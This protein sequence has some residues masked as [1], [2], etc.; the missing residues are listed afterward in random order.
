M[1]EMNDESIVDKVEAAM[2]ADCQNSARGCADVAS[3][4]EVAEHIFELL[5]AEMPEEQR[6]RMH[7]HCEECSHCSQ[8]TDAEAHVREIIKRSCCGQSA[9]ATLRMRISSQ[10]SILRASME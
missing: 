1:N 9:P 10:I 7:R 2:L 8:M 6:A 4:E 3:C 5:D